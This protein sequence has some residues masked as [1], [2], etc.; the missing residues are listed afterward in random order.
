M[1]SLSL[2]LLPVIL[3]SPPLLAA[4]VVGSG[5]PGSCTEAALN[6]ALVGGGNVTFN[7][8]PSPVTIAIT[9]QKTIAA[10]TTIDGGNLVT[11]DGGNATRLFLT[12]YQVPFTVRNLTLQNAR[13]ADVGGAIRA[14]Y[15]APLTVSDSRFYNN[16]CTQAGPDVGGGAIYVQGGDTLI[17][18]VTFS[19][20]R[21]GN[22]GAMGNL[23]SR[24]T[25]EDSAF[26][27]NQTNAAGTGGG[28]GG[29]LYV[30]GSNAGSITIRRV[31][32]D[33]NVA[34]SHGGAIHTYLYAGASQLVVEDVLF[35]NNST[36]NNGGAIYHQNGG[37][38]ID[39][40][41]FTGN[42]TVGQGGALW[43]LE[44]WSGRSATAPSRATGPTAC[45]RTTA[46]PAWA[47]RSCS[48]PTTT[49]RSR[50]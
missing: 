15:Q 38:T 41:T 36:Q 42:Q 29:A 35:R 13:T 31:V 5:T 37:L 22:G 33:G 14:G 32:F 49:S 23:Q 46:R 11:L 2:L 1:R 21:G 27:N 20:N 19:G 30:D 48:T 17:Q 6:T 43:L 26:L 7:C 9:S 3:F 18:R 12:N 25:I 44:T 39:R 4:G 34:T 10:A 24:T 40:S 47:A 16:T 8:G 50:T 28:A 45:G